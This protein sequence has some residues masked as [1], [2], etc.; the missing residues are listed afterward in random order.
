[1]RIATNYLGAEP[2]FTIQYA[3]RNLDSSPSDLRLQ[4]LLPRIEKFM[5]NLDGLWYYLMVIAVFVLSI[6][7]GLGMAVARVSGKGSRVRGVVGAVGEVKGMLK[8]S[9]GSR[10]KT[11]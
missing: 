6:V 5:R 10:I 7:E 9:R 8:L 4:A 11:L 1:M 2:P 3:E